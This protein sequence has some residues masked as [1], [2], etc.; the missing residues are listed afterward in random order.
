M[1]NEALRVNRDGFAKMQAERCAKGLDQYRAWNDIG[2]RFAS[3][4]A[5]VVAEQNR[6]NAGVEWRIRDFDFCYRLS[7]GFNGRPDAQRGQ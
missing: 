6:A 7:L 5:I 1:L 4:G 2:G 3:G